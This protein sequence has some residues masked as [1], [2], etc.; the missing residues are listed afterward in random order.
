MKHCYW[1]VRLPRNNKRN[2][3]KRRVWVL[4]RNWTWLKLLN[5]DNNLSCLLTNGILCCIVSQL[6][7]RN[8]VISDNIMNID[9]PSMMVYLLL[10]IFTIN[11]SKNTQRRLKWKWIYTSLHN[12]YQR[13]YSKAIN[14]VITTIM[15]R[16]RSHGN[17][18][19][20]FCT[21]AVVNH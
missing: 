4:L 18:V 20:L 17:L 5:M 9:S 8:A 2:W 13:K 10:S 14:I 12:V 11:S 3:S 15:D 7:I 19:D 6:G 21:Q 16:F 1:L